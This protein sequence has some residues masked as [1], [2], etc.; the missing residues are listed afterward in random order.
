MA[1]GARVFVPT[2]TSPTHGSSCLLVKGPTAHQLLVPGAAERLGSVL[3][4]AE[5]G[6]RLGG[7][8]LSSCP[9]FESGA[10]H[11]PEGAFPLPLAPTCAA[12]SC[13]P[14]NPHAQTIPK[15]PLPPGH[16][17]LCV[18]SLAPP[19]PMRPQLGMG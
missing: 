2:A 8:T 14:T 4:P 1:R 3:V 12:S 16:T 15:C 9:A 6:C 19:G 11:S 10:A 18:L 13:G 5:A 7:S 17:A